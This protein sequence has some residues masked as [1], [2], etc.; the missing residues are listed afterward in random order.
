MKLTA[1][2][3]TLD[4]AAAGSLGVVQDITEQ[5]RAEESLRFREEYFRVLLENAS[6]L[7]SIIDLD[8]SVLY[9]SL[10]SER[11]LGRSAEDIVGRDFRQLLHEDDR[12]SFTATLQQTLKADSGSASVQLRLRHRDGH[13][14]HYESLCN[15]L[16]QNPVIGGIVVTSRD[17][18]RRLE[19]EA[20]L[21]RERALFQQLF[22][23][24]PAAIAILDDDDRVL[25]VN[26][27]FTDLFQYSL[28]EMQGRQLGSLIVPPDLLG[29]ADQ[30][31]KLVFGRQTIDHETLRQRK[32]GSQVDVSI[33]GYPV[34]LAEG[35]TG[36]FGLYTDITERKQAERRLFHDAFHDPLTG[37]PNR[38]LL[39]ERL[40]RGLRRAKRRAD[41]RFALLF[42]DLDRFKEINDSL[43][44]AAGD[45]V[46]IET[47]RRLE[48]CLRPGDTTARLAGDEFI[49][50]LEDVGRVADASRVSE[51]V[52]AALARPYEVAGQTLEV[53]GSLGMVFSSPSYTSSEALIRD[54]DIAMYRAK[55][56]GRGRQEIFDEDMQRSAVERQRLES[57]LARAIERQE[58]ELHYQPIVSLADGRIVA[59]E[60]LVRWRHPDRGLLGPAEL[61]PAAESTGLIVPLGRWILEQACR[62]IIEWQR[63][64]GREHIR[65]GI[66]LSESQLLSPEFLDDVEAVFAETG[67]RPDTLVFEVQESLLVDTPE[68]IARLWQL[69]RRGCRLQL[70]D[71]GTGH[72]SLGELYRSPIEALK[73]DRSLISRMPRDVELV[74]AASSL[75]AH[76]GLTVIAEGVETEAQSAQVRELG[77]TH[78]QG[79]RFSRP[80]ASEAATALL[81][82]EPRQ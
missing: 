52:L 9:Q 17:V 65:I 64:S 61:I 5:R 7:I 16:I 13:C 10:S 60:A 26:R 81:A 11:L 31:S 8:G 62:Q 57:E 21:Q 19:V 28:E 74:R 68:S 29:E 47:A 75:G 36:A 40:E 3:L 46:L 14:C 6:D 32:D 41:Y 22:R 44:H 58:Q 39:A 4:G 25:D 66:N 34:E 42:I 67:A 45:E 18:T 27:G 59:F 2:P 38:T 50:L 70:D 49:I 78:A 37:L 80:L 55:R 33:L 35:R 15:N 72:T 53:S 30:L 56:R 43:G 54:A 63:S 69:R 24:S 20:Q 76:L 73:V 23:N 48:G 1:A 51:R 82:E 71:F 79:F 77:I 12:E